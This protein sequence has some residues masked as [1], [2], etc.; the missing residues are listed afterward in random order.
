MDE[1]LIKCCNISLL[2]VG[3]GGEAVRI[4]LSALSVLKQVCKGKKTTDT[5]TTPAY[6]KT[7]KAKEQDKAKKIKRW[8][9]MAIVLNMKGFIARS[10][11]SK[12]K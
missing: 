11:Q 5:E 9:K 1:R 2:L 7:I 4:I 10:S 8:R 12:M 3:C 6:K